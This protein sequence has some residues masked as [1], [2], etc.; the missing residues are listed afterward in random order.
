MAYLNQVVEL[1]AIPHNCLSQCRAIDSCAG[2]DLY[3]ISQNYGTG[4]NDLV[5]GTIV[6]FRISETIR[7]DYRVGLYYA[8]PAD[9]HTATYHAS[10]V[11][12][13]SFTDSRSLFDRKAA[14]LLVL[15]Q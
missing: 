6:S 12:G 3:I 7:T 11:N 2:S 4:L 15:Q 1:R 14:I 10:R 8:T 13:T 9:Y 5:P